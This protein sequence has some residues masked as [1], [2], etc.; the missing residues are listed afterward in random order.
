[1]LCPQLPVG[2]WTWTFSSMKCLSRQTYRS[3]LKKGR[4]TWRQENGAISLPSE[5]SRKRGERCIFS[6]VVLPTASCHSNTLSFP[7]SFPS[8]HSGGGIKGT[9]LDASSACVL[10]LSAPVAPPTLHKTR[11]RIR[12]PGMKP[13]SD[14]TGPLNFWPIQYPYSTNQC[15]AL[16][17][18]KTAALCRVQG[19]EVETSLSVNKMYDELQYSSTFPFFPTVW[20]LMVLKLKIGT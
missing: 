2:W 3:R 6:L 1:M 7:F 13:L 18:L 17:R 11:I 16:K 4:S 15:V 9:F 19:L 14:T 8:F 20:I 10:P 5:F 12:Y